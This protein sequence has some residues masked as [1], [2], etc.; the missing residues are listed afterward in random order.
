MRK[1]I[2]D[3]RFKEHIQSLLDDIDFRKKVEQRKKDP[4]KVYA[5]KVKDLA[6]YVLDNKIEPYF[7]ATSV[8]LGS[9]GSQANS[10]DAGV[11]FCLK[12][13]QDLAKKNNEQK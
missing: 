7:S 3:Y 6:R 9:A 1:E 12:I 13:K 2:D 4:E 11:H 5:A 10:W 8:D